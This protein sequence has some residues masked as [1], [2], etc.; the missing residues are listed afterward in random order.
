MLPV[1]DIAAAAARA[2]IPTPNALQQ[3]VWSAG[4]DR[5]II[6]SPTGSGKTMAFGGA[7]LRRLGSPGHGPQALVLAPSRELVIQIS[8]VLRGLLAGYRVTAFYGRHSM[9][10]EV[11]SLAGRPDVI[12]ATP[13]RLLDHLNRGNLSPEGINILVIDEYDKC[14]ELGFSGEMSRIARR[15]GKLSTV[16]LTSATRATDLP[17][18]IDA[19]KAT[20]IDNLG[21]E[22]PAARM[23]ISRVES[24]GRDKIETLEKLLSTLENRRTIV[25]VNHRD[26]AERVR[27]HL[28]RDGF[29]A[30]LY[31]GGLEQIDRE[32]AVFCLDNDTVPVMVATDLAGRGL[33]IDSVGAVV[34]YH[35]PPTPE[36]WTHRNGRT[37]RVDAEGDIYVIT[38]PDEE[39]PDYI[40]CDD[41]LNL[42]ETVQKTARPS[43]VTYY[44][45]AGRKEKI[46]RGDIAGF[47]MKTAGIESNA[48]GKITVRDHG[49]YVALDRS[50][51]PVIAALE[52]PKIKG[53]RV[54]ISPLDKR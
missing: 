34:H 20:V 47:L 51:M 33:D 38:A 16:I 5:L 44:I 46:S 7:L 45:N 24:A 1:K 26:A 18:Y 8:E 25:F 21:G 40:V 50:A 48:V 12:V 41:T 23:H 9:T 14:L 30:S 19:P 6:L 32:R 49:A 2:G 35:L 22:N 28:L 39:L 4:G 3:Q 15:L 43:K 29:N 17:D 31:H 27:E 36:N 53:K 54:R 42:P 11:N 10:D 37:A 52:S 13:G